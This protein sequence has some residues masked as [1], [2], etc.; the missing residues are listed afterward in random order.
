MMRFQRGKHSLKDCVIVD[1]WVIVWGYGHGNYGM[2]T[3]PFAA[4]VQVV[5]AYV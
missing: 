4:N 2:E 3:N 1:L 5:L